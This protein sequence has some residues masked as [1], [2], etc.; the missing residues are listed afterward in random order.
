MFRKLFLISFLTTSYLSLAS[1]VSALK[2]GPHMVCNTNP[3]SFADVRSEYNQLNGWSGID[4]KIPATII[5]STDSSQE[6]LSQIFLAARNNGIVPY[7]RLI[8][9]DF[10]GQISADEIN[11]F[12]SNLNLALTELGVSGIY[13]SPGNEPN[14]QAEWQGGDKIE[15]LAIALQTLIN[16]ADRYKVAFPPLDLYYEGGTWKNFITDFNNKHHDLLVKIG[17]EGAF[18]AVSYTE[19]NDRNP[20]KWKEEQ[21]WLKSV[22]INAKFLLYEANLHPGVGAPAEMQADY[23]KEIYPV[24]NADASLEMIT[25][26]SRAKPE[27]N[28]ASEDNPYLMLVIKED[29]SQAKFIP[30]PHPMDNCGGRA[31]IRIPVVKKTSDEIIHQFNF[32]TYI[33]EKIKEKIWGGNSGLVNLETV[34]TPDFQAVYKTASDQAFNSLLPAQLQDR[35]R[36]NNTSEQL[37]MKTASPVCNGQN[38]SNEGSDSADLFNARKAS[39]AYVLS[40]LLSP[41]LINNEKGVIRNQPNSYYNYVVEEDKTSDLKIFDCGPVQRGEEIPFLLADLLNKKRTTWSAGFDEGE[42]V[43]AAQTSSQAQANQPT[44]TPVQKSHPFTIKNNVNLATPLKALASIFTGD[45][46]FVRSFLPAFFA[47]QYL[48]QAGKTENQVSTRTE[49]ETQKKASFVFDNAKEMIETNK[50]FKNSL[51]PAIF[52]E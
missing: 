12:T 29:G 10:Y 13:L 23:I 48:N 43:L 1:P 27:I 7:V 15:S 46:G 5:V 14:Q 34:N 2:F 32:I 19:V 41:D 47:D 33:I 50:M 45:N 8:G 18:A 30:F 20:N 37:S 17:R 9:A 26:F 35:V 36:R 39:T 40:D 25:P 28:I 49:S 52:Q 4:N 3:E 31:N 22:G 44:S 42:S 11:G 21:N 6:S 38:P 24:Y 16:G 51:L